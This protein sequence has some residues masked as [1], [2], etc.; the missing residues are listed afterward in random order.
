MVYRDIWVVVKLISQERMIQTT[1][2]P[3]KNPK[4]KL[5]NDLS[6]EEH[7]TRYPGAAVGTQLDFDAELESVLKKQVI[8]DYDNDDDDDDNYDD[9]TFAIFLI[10]DP[11]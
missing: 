2:F 1:R 5:F 9:Y 6:E 11:P 4:K 8:D 3:M 7:I 10:S